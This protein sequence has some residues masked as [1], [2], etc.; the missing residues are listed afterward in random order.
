[1]ATPSEKA[2]PVRL[3]N[4]TVPRLFSSFFSVPQTLERALGL[5]RL[6]A[7]KID[8]HRT[9]VLGIV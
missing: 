1:M 3:V 5:P 9:Y 8:S 2:W 7:L 4:S 6:E